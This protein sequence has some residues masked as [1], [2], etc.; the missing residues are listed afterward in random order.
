MKTP[1]NNTDNR[2]HEPLHLPWPPEAIP[3]LRIDPRNPDHHL[4]NNNGTF[5]IGLTLVYPDTRTER[6]RYS[7]KTKNRALARKRRDAVLEAAARRPR[8]PSV[9]MVAAGS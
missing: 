7:L 4:W 3:S 6:V 5:Y 8:P 9:K 2:S 1:E